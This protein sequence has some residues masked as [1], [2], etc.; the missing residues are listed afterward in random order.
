M[1]SVRR[2]YKDS[3]FRDIFND[4]VRLSDVYTALMGERVE[5]SEIRLTTIDEIFFGSEKNDVSFLVQDRHIV[6]LEHQ[7]TVNANMPLRLLWYVAELYRQYVD[8]K[9]PYRSKRIALP[10]PTFYVF[11]NGWVEMPQEWHL[12]LSDSFGDAAGAMELI[13]NVLNINAEAGHPI[14]ARCLPLR[15]YSA[16]VA[17]VRDCVHSGTALV[18]AVPEAIRYCIAHNY[19]PEYFTNKLEKEVFD[20][21]NFEWDEELARQV[22][23]E[24]AWEDG[25]ESGMQ[26]GMQ[27]GVQQGMQQAL[28]ASIGNLMKSMNF[29]VEKA[30]DVLQIPPAERA[31]YA[32][33]VQAP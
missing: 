15:A 9:A 32:A 16:F 22:R 7:S 19:L 23:A 2:T 26:Q 13:V 29:S 3:L 24:E 18:R 14:L 8:P 5:P 10:A 6:L 30:M 27:Q 28:A 12:R 11:Y 33:L 1:R 21:V 4:T 20:M 31:K 25:M 17:K